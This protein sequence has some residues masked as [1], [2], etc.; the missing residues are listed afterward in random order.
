MQRSFPP[1]QRYLQRPDD[2]GCIENSVPD[3][4]RGKAISQRRCNMEI[5]KYVFRAVAALNAG[6]L[7]H[8]AHGGDRTIE[9]PFDLERG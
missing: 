3:L 2:V 8:V 1:I 6:L 9:E 4:C 7:A 5:D